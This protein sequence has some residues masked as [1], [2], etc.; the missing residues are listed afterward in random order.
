MHRQQIE[1]CNEK[2]ESGIEGV[3]IDYSRL[4]NANGPFSFKK[5]GGT[6]TLMPN[7][8]HVINMLTKFEI[9]QDEM[10]AITFLQW[11]SRNI[12]YLTD[13]VSCGKTLSI[14]CLIASRKL[15]D[16]QYSKTIIV[17]GGKMVGHWYSELVSVGLV[18]FVG[19][20]PTKVMPPNYNVDCILVTI[21]SLSLYLGMPMYRIVFDEVENL[22]GHVDFE[23][24]TS[25]ILVSATPGRAGWAVRK[26]RNR[27]P[28]ALLAVSFYSLTAFG[29]FAL[30]AFG[31]IIIVDNFL[32]LF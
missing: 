4:Q 8:L 18:V 26:V 15:V 13:P 3:T 10:P 14:A 9:E 1:S 22:S 17:C 5:S 19:N 6:R 7:Q 2:L 11:Q 31:N 20:S 23:L 32:F 21:G 16:E 24:Y 25:R 28:N 30:T 27:N 29:R 12:A